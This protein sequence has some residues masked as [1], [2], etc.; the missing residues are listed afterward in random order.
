MMN[1][2]FPC[3]ASA[4]KGDGSDWTWDF[5]VSDEEYARL[6]KASEEAEDLRDCPDISDIYDRLYDEML[7]EQADVY[8]AD[9]D[10]L[11]E[12]RDDLDLEEDDEITT[13]QV[14][15]YLKDRYTWGIRFPEEFYE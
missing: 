9:D 11:E 7:S 5:E 12:V 2:S 6:K 3:W 8:L 4:G 13:E 1:L 10:L 15:D 14:I